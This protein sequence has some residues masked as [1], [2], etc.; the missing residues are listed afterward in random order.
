MTRARPLCL[1]LA[2][3]CLCPA[4]AAAQPRCRPMA[5]PTVGAEDPPSQYAAFCADHPASCALTGE[6]VIAWSAE[7]FQQLGEVNRAVNA[8]VE[9]VADMDHLGLEEDWDLPHDCRGDC[10]DF[11]L[12]KRERLVALGL[13]SAALTMA[14]GFHRVQVF[15][16]AVLLVETTAGT[17]V[18]D[19]LSG[20]VLCWD[21]VPYMFT[22]RE[23]PDGTWLRFERRD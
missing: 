7:V 4:P 8:E 10:E 9:F 21:A 11:A 5:L 16:H 13:P 19:N 1:L 20:E 14:I 23:Q 22:R 6:P 18:L 17:L 15:P 12:E 2:A 3:V